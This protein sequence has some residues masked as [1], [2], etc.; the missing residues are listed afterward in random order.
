MR[1]TATLRTTSNTLPDSILLSGV[2]KGSGVRLTLSARLI[3]MGQTDI[4]TTRDTTVQVGNAGGDTVRI[5]SIVSNNP[6]ISAT[7]STIHF[8]PTS[9]SSETANIR[10]QG[11]GIDT[12]LIVI[13]VGSIAT[14]SDDEYARE[15]QMTVVPNPVHT[16]AAV[17]FILTHASSVTAVLCD[18]K[19]REVSQL[20]LGQL[21]AGTSE[22]SL[23]PALA[24]IP[25]GTY[26]I[27]M[28]TDKGTATKKIVLSR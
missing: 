21:D 9:T 8:T 11:S 5:T 15:L 10:L 14:V 17:Q 7:P 24:T 13:G 18:A 2:G 6:V 22:F 20:F 16:S 25:D 12:T 19:G 23:F 26:F 4:G 3:T 28:T 1:L 27:R